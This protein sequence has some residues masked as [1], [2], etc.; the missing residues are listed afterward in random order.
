MSTPKVVSISAREAVWRARSISELAKSLYI[1]GT[2]GRNPSADYPFTAKN[3]V[4]GSDCIG[5]V[6]WCLGLDRYQPIDGHDIEYPFY[7]GW[8]NTDSMLMDVSGAQKY[9]LH[10]YDE[11]VQPGD[12]VVYPSVWKDG[13]MV[14]MGHIALVVS[15]P[16]RKPTE[17]R[18][19]WFKRIRV[20]D[21]A[22]AAK[23]KILGR[24]VAE[25]DATLWLKPD[26]MWVR[27]K[28]Q[29]APAP[30]LDLTPLPG[31]DNVMVTPKLGDRVL[32]Y[33]TPMM[34]GAD[35]KQLQI[36]LAKKG[37]SVSLDGWYGGVTELA[38]SRFQAT[39]WL[40]IDGIVGPATLAKLLAK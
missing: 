39:C 38:V 7:E 13:K 8:I 20:I 29:A 34:G 5:F 14:R 27:Y 1:L 3:G 31:L 19:E 9:F 21:C 36:L 2:G 22:A 12:C 26:A 4:L 33:T 37:F 18:A 23:R 6:L 15:V 35:V 28:G 11:E 40:A 25:R 17:T 30:K 10:I 32:K 16:T 24:A